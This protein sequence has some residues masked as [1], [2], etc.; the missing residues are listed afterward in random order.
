MRKKT[1]ITI[2]IV[3]VTNLVI[4]QPVLTNLQDNPVLIKYNKTHKLIKIKNTTDTLTLPVFDDFAKQGIYP[5]SSIWLDMSVYINNTS[6]ENPPSIGV[7]TFDALDSIGHLYDNA[8]PNKFIADKLTSKPIN[9]D[10]LPSDSIYLS[11]Y[12][13]ARGFT[14]NAPEAGDSLVLEFKTPQTEWTHIWVAIFDSTFDFKKVMIPITDTTFLKKGFQFRFYNY[15]SIGGSYLPSWSFNSDYWNLDFVNLN[16]N[17]SYLDTINDLTFIYKFDNLLKTYTAIPWTHFNYDNSYD[18]KQINIHYKNLGYDTINCTRFFT[19]DNYADA[20]PK[21]INNFGTDNVLPFSEQNETIN[22][23]NNTFENYN[24]I[25]SADWHIKLYLK[26]DTISA[27][28]IYRWND[29]ITYCQHFYNYYAYDDGTA[30][31]GYGISGTG[32]SSA[33]IAYKFNTI[34][35]DTL[36]AFQIFF[37]RTRND[38]T[39]TIPIYLTV[40]D[41]LNGK[42][43]NIIYQQ[44]TTTPIFKDSI[45]EFVNYK[46]DNPIFIQDT[47]FIGWQKTTEDLINIGFDNNNDTKEKLFYNISG[48]WIQSTFKGS[49]MLRPVFGKILPAGINKTKKL[50]NVKIYPNPVNN[51]INIS[52]ADYSSNDDVIIYNN[53]GA[54][55]YKSKIKSQI[56]LSN[57]SQ[58]IYF[59]KIVS[60]KK[61][62]ATKKII[63]IH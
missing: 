12:Y 61:I 6:G 14:G 4:S 26:T 44:S 5:D 36:R 29:T 62:I 42:P 15:A 39:E 22:Y 28:K 30:E 2:I 48:A 40:W 24:L 46:L 43:N 1:Y 58:G 38:Y 55:T 63:I 23:T 51:F 17:R 8:G 10:Y 50:K 32:T 45:Y 56:D 11:F 16:K 13:Q 9:L 19:R 31:N 57:I 33:M 34:M 18:K 3:F 52:Y 7:A 54:I 60:N 27:R 37:N 47:F 35:P 21:L 49:L 53:L 59:L 20:S 41:N 25:D